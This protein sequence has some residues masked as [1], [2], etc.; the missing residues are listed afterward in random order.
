MKFSFNSSKKIG[1]EG[2][3]AWIYSTKE[4]FANASA[5][6]FE[7][8]NCHGKIKTT[9]SDRIYFVVEGEGEFIIND[10]VIPVQE[11]DVVIVPK[12][13]P[14]DYQ[15]VNN[16][17]LKLFLVHVPAYDEKYEVQLE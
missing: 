2:L 1:W 7:V 15:A 5:I 9:L 12:N 8:T 4:D 10:K 16:N 14:Y 11:K 17:T 3:K 13:T 6:Y